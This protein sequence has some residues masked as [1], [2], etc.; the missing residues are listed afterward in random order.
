LGGLAAALFGLQVTRTLRSCRR[1]NPD[2]GIRYALTAVGYLML[3]A[4][5]GVALAA[6]VVRDDALAAR[7]GFAYG[8]LGLGGWVS[9]MIMG[10]MYKIVPFLVWYLAYSDRLGLG[11]VPG[12][13]DLYSVRAQRWGYWLLNTGILGTAAALAWGEPASLRTATGLLAA[14]VLIFVLN[15]A[16]VFRHLIRPVVVPIPSVGGRR[17]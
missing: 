6:G 10:M 7:L 5:L 17:A 1:R 11:R 9:V 12:L 13:A 15:M 8:F 4:L 14:A 16:G 2:W 3:A